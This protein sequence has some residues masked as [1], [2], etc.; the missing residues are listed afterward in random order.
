VALKFGTEVWV[1][2]KREQRLEATQM[3]F[4]RHVV[5]INK[6]DG[7]RNKSVREKL[8]VQNSV[9]EVGHCQHERLQHLKS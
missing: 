9:R 3:E 2:K 6:L 8:V 4:L 1:L 7:E 5:G